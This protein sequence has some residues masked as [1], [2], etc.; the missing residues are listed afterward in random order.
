MNPERL[1]AT[2]TRMAR[3]PGGRRLF[4]L[5]IGRGVPYSGSIGA[6]VESFTRGAAIVS[7][8]DRRRVRN[9]LGSIHAIALAN[10]AELTSGLAM[11][12]AA[13]SGVRGI[14]TALRIEY[15]K[16]AR[17]RLLAESHREPPEVSEPGEHDVITTVRDGDGDVV[18]VATVTWRLA[19]L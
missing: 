8:P 4:A 5:F 1:L 15:H 7:M 12:T 19:P 18:A 3:L 9:H 17:G 6:V 16:K 14:V 10:L 2:W 13:G 11:L